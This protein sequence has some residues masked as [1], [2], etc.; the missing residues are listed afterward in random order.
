MIK[1]VNAFGTMG[2]TCISGIR[3]L[4]VC[5]L[6]WGVVLGCTEE[7]GTQVASPALLETGADAILTG[8]RHQITIDGVR[9]AEIYADTAYSFSDSSVYHLI[10]PTLEL[11]EEGTGVRR[12]QVEAEWGRFNPGTREMLARGN[13]VLIIAEGNRRVE[14]QELNYA[15]GGDRIWSDSF[16]VMTEPGR[17]SEGLGF[18]TD[19]E[20]RN[21]TIGP[22]SIRNVPTV[23][24]GQVGD[25]AQ[26][27]EGRPGVLPDSG[28]GQPA[29]DPD[30]GT[31]PIPSEP[32]D[33]AGVGRPEVRPD[34]TGAL[35]KARAPESGGG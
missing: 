18:D 13:V 27:I 25:S 16:T 12:A 35:G 3:G 17:I 1:K 2:I 14:S 20:F 8:L 28:G 7:D 26:G 10:G 19:L 21:A 22:G 4:L 33:T 34:T 15:P 24:P 5:L 23:Q 29:V 6:S 32:P 9:E 30:T 31:V 11:F